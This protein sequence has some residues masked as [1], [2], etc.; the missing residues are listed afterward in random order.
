MAE[1]M[2]SGS[3]DEE[4]IE[5]FKNFGPSSE[6]DG[7]TLRMLTETLKKEG[8]SITEEETAFLFDYVDVD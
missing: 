5:A 1:S 4:M 7:I 8:E 6:Y 2:G 3:E